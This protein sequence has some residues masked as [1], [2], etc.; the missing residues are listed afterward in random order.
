M[1]GF[2]P[3]GNSAVM[4]P[5]PSTLL[6]TISAVPRRTLNLLESVFWKGVLPISNAGNQTFVVPEG[7]RTSTRVIT[8]NVRQLAAFAPFASKDPVPAN[9]RPTEV[10]AVDRRKLRRF[11]E[12]LFRRVLS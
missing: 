7:L 2:T 8:S 4:I 6:A 12:A 10:V 5:S 11:I 1:T 9:A 3:T